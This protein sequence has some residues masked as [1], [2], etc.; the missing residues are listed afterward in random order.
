[1]TRLTYDAVI[2]VLYNDAAAG[3]VL[4][5]EQQSLAVQAVAVFVPGYNWTDYSTEA[6]NIDALVGDTL[7]ALT[8]TE[9][10]PPMQSTQSRVTLWHKFAVVDTGNAIQENF[11]AA[12][13][14]G[15]YWRQNTAAINDT[16]HQRV[17]LA[18]GDYQI[19]VV[20]IRLTVNGKLTLTVQPVAG[21]SSVSPFVAVDL[22][23]AT[24]RNQVLTGS[25]TL[26]V[27]GAMD[28]YNFVQFAGTGGGFGL[29]LTMTEI[30]RTS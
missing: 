17:W 24:L 29:P 8:N 20:Y 1:M 27:S 14:F 9:V 4:T 26:A 30:W 28:V 2:T 22:S 3:I 15:V 18:A 16:N 25:F 21:G 23:G 7:A 6:D 19:R 5:P 11:D 12:Q 13:L 10:P